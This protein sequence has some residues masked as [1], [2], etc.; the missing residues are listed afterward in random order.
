MRNS[1]D[2]FVLHELEAKGLTFAP[3]ASDRQLLRLVFLDLTG[4]PP[5][6]EETLAFLNDDAPNA[7]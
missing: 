4:I 2:A 7:Y 5:T 6:R 3:D 1:I